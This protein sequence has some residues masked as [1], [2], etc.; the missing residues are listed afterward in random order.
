MR[1]IKKKILHSLK[2]TDPE[3]ESYQR[4]KLCRI[5]FYNFL[6]TGPHR[7]HHWDTSVFL[8]LDASPTRTHRCKPRRATH[9]YK[10][11][12]HAICFNKK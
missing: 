9:A 3:N 7:C 2:P 10:L 5:H 4:T 1:M 8:N 11:L 12:Y 6:K